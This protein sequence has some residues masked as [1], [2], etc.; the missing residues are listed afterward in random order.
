M[1]S[2][3]KWRRSWKN[4]ADKSGVYEKWWLDIEFFLSHL[5]Q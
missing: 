1:V 2:G 5:C 3:W 4:K